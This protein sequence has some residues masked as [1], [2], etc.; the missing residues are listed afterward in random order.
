MA[1]FA[2]A[3]SMGT[4]V[5]YDTKIMVGGPKQSYVHIE[6]EVGNAIKSAI[7]QPDSSGRA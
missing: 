4:T 6:P 5:S 3:D 7:I 1:K 2:M